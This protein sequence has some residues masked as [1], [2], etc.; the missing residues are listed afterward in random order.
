MMTLSRVMFVMCIVPCAVGAVAG[1]VT[2]VACDPSSALG[3][4]E[5]MAAASIPASPAK[6]RGTVHP[7]A[8][9][10]SVRSCGVQLKIAVDWVK[11]DAKAPDTLRLDFTGKGKFGGAPAVGLKSATP[12]PAKDTLRTTFGPQ[13][14]QA[15]LLGGTIPVVVRGRY[16][17]G[18]FRGRFYRN[19]MLK[20]GTGI[21]GKGRFGKR[22]LPVRIIDGNENL[23]LGD[24][25]R[26]ERQGAVAVKGDTLAIDL[27]DGSFTKDVI[28][29]CYGSPIKVNGAW[30]SV[31]L[32]ANGKTLT[33]EP[34]D[35]KMGKLHIKH[36]KWACRLVG[37]KHTLH[38][39]G[40]S[41]P[42]AVPAGK[43]MVTKYTEWGP[44]GPDGKR[45]LLT[46]GNEFSSRTVALGTATVTVEA[47]K[48][49]GLNVGSPLTGSVTATHRAD[50]TIVLKMVLLDAAGRKI[51]Y[52]CLADGSRPGK[53]KITVRNADGKVVYTCSLE[54]G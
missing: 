8:I 28:K 22:V 15:A 9:M 39:S 32:A 35:V 44:A 7:K 5:W 6:G 30:Y 42:V 29:G 50:N 36:L 1:E 33:V 40:G 25:W 4:Q 51:D 14:V 24:A 19:L 54:Y 43:Y 47:G 17:T 53:P 10:L 41:E 3:Y 18:K 38:V 16:L 20:I 12:S 52:L 45:A 27:G 49:A 13:T 31:S 2:P 11:P 26:I 23:K 21:E 37:E 46:Y 34:A 48:T